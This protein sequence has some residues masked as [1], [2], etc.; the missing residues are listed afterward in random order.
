MN[1][2]HAPDVFVA[3]FGVLA[4][5]ALVGG[6]GMLFNRRARPFGL[7]LLGLLLCA[8]FFV[9]ADVS[10]HEPA[11]E[12]AVLGLEAQ[13]A[14]QQALAQMQAEILKTQRLAAH[15]GDAVVQHSPEG[16][17]LETYPDGMQITQRWGSGK[18]EII[19]EAD[20]RL[21]AAQG[22]S[23][24]S[25]VKAW[26]LF[27]PLLALVV[28]LIAVK[29]RRQCGS[30]RGWAAA[31]AAALLALG[32]IFLA[33]AAEH[34]APVA[35]IV[36][37]PTPPM[38]LADAVHEL[39]STA[40]SI[41]RQHA[42]FDAQSL[43][44]MWAHLTAPRINL[45]ESTA[46]ELT[47]SQRELAAAAKVVLSASVPGADPFTQGW[48]A[49][50]AKAIVAAAKPKDASAREMG[51]L[52]SGAGAV[53]SLSSDAIAPQAPEPPTPHAVPAE[54]ASAQIG[55]AK[56][57]VEAQP[58]AI[59]VKEVGPPRPRPDWVDNPPT[60]VGNPRRIAVHT[61]PYSTVEECYAQL[62]EDLREAVRQRIEEKAREANG[63]RPV[64]VPDLEQ[65]HI[66]TDYIFSELCRE[67]D[68]IETVQMSAPLGEMLRA[69]ALLE[70]TPQQ[71]ELLVD[72]WRAYARRENVEAV[73]ILSTLVV[74]ALAFV[75][76][77]LKIDTWTRGYYT[78]RLFLGV[79]AAI[80]AV[81]ALLA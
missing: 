81:L 12:I 73:G 22:V 44:T 51:E 33:R 35:T 45:D 42:N 64:R 50:A 70:F 26:I 77:L 68:Y 72:R 66:S 47:E 3:W 34:R 76:G 28:A 11:T 1:A 43:E 5:L 65:L 27:A 17:V 4:L 8:F 14:Q 31:G 74:G 53:V 40:D 67:G 20:P 63:G 39:A 75:Y 29:S 52:P 24:H 13:H 6:I 36:Q 78:K 56:R 80:I 41:E 62:R 57:R 61:D 55:E 48:L 46:K 25:S 7:A 9:R 16:W 23:R 10:T 18:R 58:V 32:L 54:P 59:P 19:R 21:S 38:V 71:D 2:N 79:P 15:M 30:G 60:L 37:T 69:H 49:N